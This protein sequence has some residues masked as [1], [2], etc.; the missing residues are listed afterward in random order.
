VRDAWTSYISP[1]DYDAHM[2]RNGQAEAN[3]RLVQSLWLRYRPAGNRLLVAGAGTGQWLD[4]GGEAL[5]GCHITCT[6]INPAFLARLQARAARAGCDVE[7]V[8]DDLERSRLEPVFDAAIVV[9]VLE[10][11][12]WRRGVESLARLDVERCFVVIQEN[13][14]DQ[15]R[16]L[17]ASREPVGTIR[18]FLTVHPQLVDR[19]ELSEAFGARGYA[20]IGAQSVDVA[21]GKRMIGTVFERT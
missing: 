17:T 4:F 12:D 3:A 18:A 10:H 1:D 11:I 19:A 15:E 13:P 2:A 7:A 21:D 20:C 14:P 5:A 9:L 6:D 8:V 16:M